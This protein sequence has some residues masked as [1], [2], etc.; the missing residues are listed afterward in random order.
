[1]PTF[2]Y[3]AKRGPND[4]VE[5]VIEAENRGGVLTY[6]TEQGYVPVRI[7]EEGA[8]ERPGAA[9]PGPA[10]VKTRRVRTAEFTAVMRQFASLMR[11]HVP[12]LRGLQI[13]R[14][15]SRDPTLRRVLQDVAETVRQGEPLSTAMGKFPNVFSPLTVSLIHSGE[16]SGA[17]DAVL[18][19]LAE[20]AEREEQ[21]RAK[22]RAA[23]TYPCFIGVVGCGTIIFLMTFVMP[24]FSHLLAGFGDRLP[25]P[26][27]LL[28]T[29]VA[30]MSSWWF[31]GTI[32][33]VMAAAVFIWRGLGTRG[34]LAFDH[35][36]LRL[37][38]LGPLIQQLE[39][40]RFARSFGV[41]VD[42]GVPI[43]RAI[44]VAIPVVHHPLIRSQLER[45]PEGL[46]Q[47]TPLSEC[48]KL[49][50]LGTPFLVNTVAVGEESGAV[51]GA[52]TEVADYYER[53]VERLLQTVATLL[54]P[55][56]VVGVGV[57]VGFIV[58]A[59][60]LPIFEMSSVIR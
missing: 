42:H 23:L 28:L 41:L 17:L 1:M 21:L 16:V 38:L 59:V 46:R 18:G 25:V 51:G 15:Q 34:R 13:L 8:T 11:S 54:E 31:W 57:V 53:E 12:L 32:L 5:G 27:R 2:H 50:A 49:L 10:T 30:W 3:T 55:A 7:N 35:L 33:G 29:V 47:G 60:L 44:D 43:L 52:M 24:R 4:I 20:Q 40:A 6:L 26:T 39:V 36:T 9:A 19:R 14:D 22:V 58:M 37:P 56:F 45:L 48:L